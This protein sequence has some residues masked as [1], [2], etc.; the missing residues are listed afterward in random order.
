VQRFRLPRE[1]ELRS[2]TRADLFNG[3]VTLSADAVAVDEA[4]F[5]PLYRTAPPKQKSAT[6]TALPYYLW[7]NRGQGSMVVWVPEA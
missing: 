6:L 7:S 4:E 2:S 3:I 1:A 5:K